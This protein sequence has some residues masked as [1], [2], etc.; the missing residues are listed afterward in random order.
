MI[1]DLQRRFLS[2]EGHTLY[3]DTLPLTNPSHFTLTEGLIYSR[4]FTLEEMR[5][6]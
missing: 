4:L 2:F 1:L 5:L 3:K 6:Q